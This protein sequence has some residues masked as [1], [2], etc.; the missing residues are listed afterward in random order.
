MSSRTEPVVPELGLEV[1]QRACD[2]VGGFTGDPQ[3]SMGDIR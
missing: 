1:R 2:R 3:T